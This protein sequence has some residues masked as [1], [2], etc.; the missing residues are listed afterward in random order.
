M[1]GLT[2]PRPQRGQCWAGSSLTSK[3]GAF[4]KKEEKKEVALRGMSIGRGIQ[5][6][7]GRGPSKVGPISQT[8]STISTASLTLVHTHA[9]VRFLNEFYSRQLRVICILISRGSVI[10]WG[11]QLGSAEHVRIW[12]NI[13][14]HFLSNPENVRIWTCQNLKMSESFQTG[15]RQ[16]LKMP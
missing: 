4:Y 8:H 10:H 5:L 7:P 1:G 9:D 6:G 12:K 3:E 16:N 15:K 14:I 13:R 2:N 11:R